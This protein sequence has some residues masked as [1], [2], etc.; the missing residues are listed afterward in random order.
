MKK[1]GYVA[2]VIIAASVFTSC[3]AIG[4]VIEPG[5]WL[6]ML[7]LAA[8]GAITAFIFKGSAKG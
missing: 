8:A 3:A 2:A 5:P 7:N 4:K 6:G 1:F